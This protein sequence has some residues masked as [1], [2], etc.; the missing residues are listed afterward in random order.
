MVQELDRI[1]GTPLWPGFEPQKIPVE[2]YDGKQTW[3]F[4]HPHPPQPFTESE[5]KGVFVVNGRDASVT[6]N[7][8]IDVGGTPTA[9]VLLPKN[10][11]VRDGAALIAHEAFHVYQH[12]HYPKWTANEADLFTYPVDDAGLLQ[13]RFMETEALRRALIAPDKTEA[14]C[15]IAEALR[16]RNSRFAGMAPA[17]VT[18]ERNSELNEG[19]ANYIQVKAAGETASFTLPSSGFYPE[20]VRQRAYQIGTAWALLLDRMT[21][22]WQREMATAKSLDELMGSK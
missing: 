19:L 1:S 3:L 5:H 8:N 2:I 16:V 12:E 17:S 20:A 10:T 9:G 6:A 14:A 18:Y 15:W 22:G 11:S 21:P 4:R 7:T 13:R